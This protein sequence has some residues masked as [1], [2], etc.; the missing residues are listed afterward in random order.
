MKPDLEEKDS[1][2]PKAALLLVVQS[3]RWEHPALH[4]GRGTAPHAAPPLPKITRFHPAFAVF[5][6]CSKPCT[7]LHRPRKMGD[8]GRLQLSLG[9][10]M[11]LADT[12][13]NSLFLQECEQEQSGN[14]TV[15][16]Q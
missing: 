10:G 7:W 9:G 12:P 3:P 15:W 11:P 16:G 1:H 2:Q 5:P 4:C 6:E 13:A 14:Q 8:T